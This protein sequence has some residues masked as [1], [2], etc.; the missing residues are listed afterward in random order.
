MIVLKKDECGLYKVAQCSLGSVI[1]RELFEK[2][3]QFVLNA[4][5]ARQKLFQNTEKGSEK[6]GNDVNNTAADEQG[7]VVYVFIV[8]VL[9]KQAE[10]VRRNRVVLQGQFVHCKGERPWRRRPTWDTSGATRS[11]GRVAAGDGGGASG[12]GRGRHGVTFRLKH[13]IAR[14]RAE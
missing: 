7:D 14:R 8:A 9:P 10:G 12:S 1:C 2:G 4:G 11:A 6:H 5:V 13:A 3:S